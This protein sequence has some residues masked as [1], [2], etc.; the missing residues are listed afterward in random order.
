MLFYYAFDISDSYV[1]TICALIMAVVGVLVLND[2]CKPY[3]RL[4]KALFVTDII[5]I[6]FCVIFL[7]NIFTLTTLDGPS[8]LVFAVFAVLAYPLMR[9][10]NYLRRKVERHYIPADDPHSIGKHLAKKQK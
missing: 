5:A 4:R 3:N 10:L 7:K 6:L 2:V 8:I 1:S 9:G